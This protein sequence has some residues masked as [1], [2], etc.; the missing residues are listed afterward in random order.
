[1]KSH[2]ENKKTSE[3]FSRDGENVLNSIAVL[4]IGL[5]DLRPK[6]PD[7]PLNCGGCGFVDCKG[8]FKGQKK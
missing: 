1:M 4:L 3:I 7:N 8:F 2:G 6:K 5:K